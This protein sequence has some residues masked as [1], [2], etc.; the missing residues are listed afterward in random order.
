MEIL[1]LKTLSEILNFHK[2]SVIAEWK[3][4]DKVGELGERTAEMIQSEKRKI[5]NNNNKITEP[6][7]SLG[8]RS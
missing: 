2:I 5:L 8:Q 4:Q 7:G 3:W 6:E 1:K